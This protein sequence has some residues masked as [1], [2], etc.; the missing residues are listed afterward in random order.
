MKTF[1]K[2]GGMNHVTACAPRPAYSK[3]P[4]AEQKRQKCASF[5]RRRRKTQNRE[6]KAGGSIKSVSSDSGTPQRADRQNLPGF[7]SRTPVFAKNHEP[8]G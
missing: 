4:F 8:G 3:A 1:A 7:G 6:K 2:R 5:S